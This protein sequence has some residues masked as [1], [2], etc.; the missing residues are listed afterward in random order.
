MRQ[1]KRFFLVCMLLAGF[2]PAASF[3]GGTGRITSYGKEKKEEV[4]YDQ[5]A[6]KE[7]QV[8]PGQVGV[9]GMKPVCG[10]DIKDGVYEVKTESSSS[11]FQVDKAVLTVQEGEMTAVLTLSGKG[12]RV[13]YMG[14]GEQAAGAE[15]S[16]YIFHEEDEDGKY[17]YEI[18]VEALDKPFACAAFSEKREKWY[19]RELLIRADSLPEG[20]VLVEISDYEKLKK[21]AKE[22]RIADLRA[23]RQEDTEPVRV[24]LEDGE[25]PVQVGFQGGSGRAFVESSALLIVRDGRAYGRI[26][27]NSPHYD[28]MKVGKETFFPVNTEGENSVFEIPIPV[29]DE[30]IPVIGDTTAMSTPHEIEYTL[31][32]YQN[33][34]PAQENSEEQEIVS[35]KKEEKASGNKVAI[36]AAAVLIC[37]MAVLGLAGKNRKKTGGKGK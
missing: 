4:H 33:S 5:V 25:Y 20:A 21:E 30:E 12:Y 8:T 29:F 14:T 6:A 3:T 1:R 37:G 23:E 22:K 9:E 15:V 35:Q 19:D 17:T 24:D 11:M 18:P 32:F 26:F 34:K 2:L 36:G 27:W 28:Y 7:D 16:E 13:L 31:I 10:S